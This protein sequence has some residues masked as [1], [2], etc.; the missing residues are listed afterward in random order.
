[1]TSR[2]VDNNR[3][4]AGTGRDGTRTPVVECAAAVAVSC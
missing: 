1:M 2:S 4:G 3:V